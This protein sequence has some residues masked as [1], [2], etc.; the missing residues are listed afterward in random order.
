MCRRQGFLDGKLMG[1]TDSG[2]ELEVPPL[3]PVQHKIRLALAGYQDFEQTKNLQAGQRDNITVTLKKYEVSQ[4]PPAKFRVTL[5]HKGSGELIIGNGVLQFHPDHGSGDSFESPL[6][7]ITYGPYYQ[8][9]LF[10]PQG[11]LEGFY[12]R[13]RDG[14]DRVFLSK[15]VPAILQL[16][17]QWGSRSPSVRSASPQ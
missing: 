3:S 14:K 9:A 7:E 17:Q 11:T 1:T 5:H 15:S 12:L 13:P 2:G 4:P 16:L 6:S 10:A 8:R